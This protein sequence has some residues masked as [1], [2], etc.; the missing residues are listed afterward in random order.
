MLTITISGTW[1]S[2]GDLQVQGYFQQHF[3]YQ[4]QAPHGSIINFNPHIQHQNVGEIIG[5][6]RNSFV[7][8]VCLVIL[9]SPLPFDVS[10]Y[11][12]YHHL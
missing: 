3:G 11:K 7:L 1:K 8:T 6:V 2:G 5:G 12:H 9:P 10:S 4:F